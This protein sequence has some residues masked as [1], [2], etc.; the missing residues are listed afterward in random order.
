MHAILALRFA[1]RSLLVR[2][3]RTTLA[4]ASV[5]LAVFTIVAISSA[6]GTLVEAQ[7]RTFADTAQPD[8]VATV[9]SLTPSL[10]A[11]L[12]RREG[13]AT[14]EART[15][16]PSRVSAGG[17]WVPVQLVGIARFDAVALDRPQLVA[18][19]WPERGEI[20]LDASARRLLGVELGSLV[21][22]QANPG[23]PVRYARV[24]GFAW[25]PARPDPALLDRL[26]GF[27]SERELRQQLG[28]DSANTLLVRVTDPA[29]AGRVA[30]ELQR[31]LAARQVASSGWSVRDPDSFLGAR[32]LRTLVLLLRAFALLGAG[33]AIFVVANTTVGLLTEERPHLGTLRSLGATRRQ[34]FALFLLPYLLLGALGGLVGAGLGVLGGRALAMLLARLAGLVLPPLAV[35]W[36]TL[37]L[38]L[39][40]GVSIAVS[41]ALLPLVATV[42]RPAAELLRGDATVPPAAPRL[43]ARLTGWLAG[44]SPVLAMSVRDPFRR[45]LR[46][47]LT[48][49]AS[50]VALAA[51][52]ASQL[53]DHSLRVTIADLY[54]RYQ[55]D[56][57]ILVNPA[58]PPT[59]AHRLQR[60]P[61]VRA[62][63]PWTLVQ[64]AI[65]PVRTDVWGV[66][67][68]TVVYR[69][70]LV[71]GTWLEPSQPPSVVLTA[72]L[73]R[74]VQAQVGTVLPLDLGRR[75]VPVRVVGIVDDESTYLGATTLGKVFVDRQVLNTLLG[76]EDRPALYALRFWNHAPETA[77]AA[78]TTVER[79]ERAL[80]PLTLLMAD[81]RAATER[82][83]AVLTVLARLVVLVIGLAAVFGI[84]NALLLDIAERRREFGVLRSLGA[85]RRALVALLVGQALVVVGIGL[86]LALPLGTVA[87]AAVLRV[88]SAELFAVPLAWELRLGVLLAGAVVL[89]A[90]AAVA[91]PLG[92]VARLRPVEVLRYE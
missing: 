42:R 21:A 5:V 57:W 17:R 43:L 8:I 78:L 83:L 86:L 46:T 16:Q 27:V 73:A 13:V 87:S 70:R 34:L 53:V 71:A 92:V 90:A 52:L 58:V 82:V 65:G 38:G 64:G 74:R 26:T 14:V 7:R 28:T 61:P 24:S 60:V 75:R 40:L 47:A 80:R 48:A 56:A 67:Q 3:I 69:P 25:V 41:G 35:A 4:A 62:A 12:S 84:A 51:V 63:E 66:P 2:R 15:V 55:A 89:A 37:A 39:A 77:G 59:Y 18:G 79:S 81:D 22:L 76:R 20:V 31:F 68:D 72:N 29:L 23:D 33:V 88:V 1:L 10:L 50:A 54:T 49:A 6:G 36:N 9:P 91:V 11:A 32:E 85:E 44:W 45:P 19:R 30:T